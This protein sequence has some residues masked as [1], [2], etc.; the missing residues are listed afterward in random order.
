MY[1]QSSSPKYKHPQKT[2]SIGSSAENSHPCALQ[3]FTL[4]LLG[5]QELQDSAVRHAASFLTTVI[6]DDSD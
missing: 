5:E 4:M 3:I 6:R 2:P 1:T